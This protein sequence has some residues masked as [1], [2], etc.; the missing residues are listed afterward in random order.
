MEARAGDVPK[1]GKVRKIQF[2][3]FFSL[4]D[5]SFVLKFAEYIYAAI[6]L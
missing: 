5:Y 6:S 4:S 3:S 1:C 2:H